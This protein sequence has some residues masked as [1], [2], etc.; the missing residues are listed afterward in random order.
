M[1]IKRHIM[2][3]VFGGLMLLSIG[4]GSGDNS[5]QESIG[6]L[7][8]NIVDESDKVTDNY[9]TVN[10]LL[11]E[12]EYEAAQDSLE[13]Y[14]QREMIKAAELRG[15]LNTMGLVPPTEE[16]IRIVLKSQINH[17]SHHLRDSRK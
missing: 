15:G 9:I 6:K 11:R 7:R 1:Q 4:C 12:G 2:P 14:L 10:N 8:M 13:N 16:Y 3:Y 17:I 5:A